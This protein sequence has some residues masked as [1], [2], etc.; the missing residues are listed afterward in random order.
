[1]VPDKQFQN[2]ESK[3][4]IKIHKKMNRSMKQIFTLLFAQL[5]MH[6]ITIKMTSFYIFFLKSRCCPYMHAPNAHK[7]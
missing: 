1:M 7:N 4:K 3:A 5:Y 2:P 6:T